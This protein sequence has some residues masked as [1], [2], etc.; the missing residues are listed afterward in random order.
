MHSVVPPLQRLVFSPPITRLVAEPLQRLARLLH[1]DRLQLQP[2]MYSVGPQ[3][4]LSVR[5]WAQ[6]VGFLDRQ[7][8]NPL[9]LGARPVLLEVGFLARLLLLSQ[10]RLVV[11]VLFQG[12]GVA[13]GPIVWF[14][15]F[16]PCSRFELGCTIKI[17]DH[18]P[19]L[20][21]P[22]LISLPLLPHN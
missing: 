15:R 12:F 9:P 4:T 19:F 16:D 13:C 5:T 10:L 21:F 14:G 7:L 3:T 20:S 8:R 18:T 17:A 6:A 1:L 2:E 22:L 11:S